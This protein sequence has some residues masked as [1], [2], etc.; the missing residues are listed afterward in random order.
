MIRLLK[1]EL[2]KQINYRAFWLICGL[3]IFALL[4][5]VFG[6][7]AIIDYMIEK[8]PQWQELKLFKKVVFN[9]PDVWQNISFVASLRIFIKPILGLIVVVIIS[10]EFSYNTVRMNI[11]Q[12]LSRN[13]FILGKV[14]IITLFAFI[15]TLLIFLSGTYLGLSH[16]IK[17]DFAHFFGKMWFLAGYFIE[18]WSYLAFA[19]LIGFLIRKTGFAIITLMGYMMIEPVLAHYM[20]DNSGQ[21]LPLNAINNVLTSPNT[22]LMEIKSANFNFDFQTHIIAGDA[23]LALSYG[24]LFIAIIWLI[25]KKRDI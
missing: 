15:S 22:S 14:L 25:L 16:S 2:N 1:I 17:I 24:F 19:L 7:P 3:Y 8:Q 9:L 11:M 12:G 13:E 4:A 5:L 21:Y 10:N 23:L 20:P 6:M 18:I